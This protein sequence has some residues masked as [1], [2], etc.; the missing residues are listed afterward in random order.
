MRSLLESVLMLL[1]FVPATAETLEVAARPTV[2]PRTSPHLKRRDTPFRCFVEL[3]QGVIVS[4]QPISVTPFKRRSEHSILIECDNASASQV[5]GKEMSLVC[6]DC[7]IKLGDAVATSPKA[8]VDHENNRLTLTGTDDHPVIL[9]FGTGGDA[10]KAS[11]KE[12]AI[13]IDN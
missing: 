9:T 5:E 10:R 6:S 7:K 13:S 1:Y 2:L 4:Y 8:I 3:G 11:A 12:L